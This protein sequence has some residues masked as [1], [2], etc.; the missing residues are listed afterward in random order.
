M[1]SPIFHRQVQSAR[2]GTVESSGSTIKAPTSGR[3]GAGGA[4]GA[5]GR[6]RDSPHT[7]VICKVM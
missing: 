2:F 1:G 7:A 5:E 3:L 6:E 4:R